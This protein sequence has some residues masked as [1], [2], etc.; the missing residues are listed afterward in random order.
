MA[1]GQ[2]RSKHVGSE[3]TVGYVSR[4]AQR[5][6]DERVIEIMSRRDAAARRDLPSD[7]V[8]SARRFSRRPVRSSG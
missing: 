5:R 3:Q 2:E 8:V 6:V 1:S 4:L 7:Q